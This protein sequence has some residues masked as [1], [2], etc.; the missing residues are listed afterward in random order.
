MQAKEMGEVAH[1]KI[2][3][4]QPLCQEGL[5]LLNKEELYIAN[6]P[7]PH[8]YLDA[9]QDAD[10]LI[11]RIGKCDA[12]TI[13]SSPALKVIGRPGVGYDSVDV[14]RATEKG[15]PVVVTPG[16]NS[17]SVAEHAV[18]MMFALAKN[19]VEA[20]NESI[21]GNWNIRD[22]HKAFE[23]K[24]KCIGLIGL[25]PIGRETA[26][27]CRGIGMQIMAYDPFFTSEQIE[28]QGIL[29]AE[30]LKQLLNTADIVSVHMP[31]VEATRDL[32]AVRE[33]QQMKP[34]ALLI[35]C[36]RGGIVNETDL[37]KALQSGVIAGAALDVFTTE[38][39]RADDPLLSAP[40]LIV[41]PHAAAQTREAVVRMATMCV[42]GC[43]AVCGG[44]KWPYVVDKNVYNHPR[45]QGKEMVTQDELEE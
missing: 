5:E 38:P 29:C 45:W 4:T 7:D 31:L 19:I 1:M 35:N 9:M 21:K 37:C 6:N 33:M 20:H 42:K 12:E 11:V 39:L 40:N 15:I 26:Q 16:A 18:A 34:A 27:I 2:V 25:G 23:L 28:Q 41:S 44:K 36:S 22:A 8:C 3:M 17:R 32:I 10:A 24:G 13:D 14:K 30:T 43:L